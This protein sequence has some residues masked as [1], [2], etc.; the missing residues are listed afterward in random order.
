MKNK[1]LDIIVICKG[2]THYNKENTKFEAV[3][4]YLSE[5]SCTELNLLT[6]RDLVR[7]LRDAFYDYL[8]TCDKPSN[9]LREFD[10]CFEKE[11]EKNSETKS[12]INAV[13]DTF[14]LTD[15]RDGDKYVNGFDSRFEVT[16]M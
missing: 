14:M 3:M 1:T 4:Q 2:R 9:E 8:D 16:L 12:Y 10:R 7:I 11:K 13:L 15:V 6:E 5:N